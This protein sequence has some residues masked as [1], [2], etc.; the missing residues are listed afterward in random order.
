MIIVQ[1]LDNSYATSLVIHNNHV[2]IT[3]GLSRKPLKL[4]VEVSIVLILPVNHSKDKPCSK[5]T[6]A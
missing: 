3:E 1:I 4:H 5:H 2:Q 6:V